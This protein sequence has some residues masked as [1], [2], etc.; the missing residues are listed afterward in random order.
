MIPS[1]LEGLTG[2]AE[3]IVGILGGS[4]LLGL[5]KL[6]DV[7]KAWRL[8]A[9]TIERDVQADAEK[10]RAR[11]EERVTAAED[12]AERATARAWWY[13]EQLMQTRDLYRSQGGDP[14]LLG[15][16]DPPPPTP[17]TPT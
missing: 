1:A 11:A 13:R 2:G 9:H 10:A 4:A 6:L 12:A 7:L 3:L 15:P 17:P 14:A 8:G 5:V 16:T